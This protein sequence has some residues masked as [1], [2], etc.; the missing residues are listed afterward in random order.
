MLKTTANFL[1]DFPGVVFHYRAKTSRYSLDFPRAVEA[2]LSVGA[3]IAT[4]EQLTAA[5]ED[6]L[7]QCDAG[8]LADQSVR[9][10]SSESLM[11]S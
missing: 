10:V 11:K 4:P 5:Y 2:C 9:Q 7:D 3:A 8:W 1:N 6:G